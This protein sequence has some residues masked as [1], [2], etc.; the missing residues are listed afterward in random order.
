MRGLTP[1][2]P[3]VPRRESPNFRI[4]L[5][6]KFNPILHCANA[7]LP[8]AVRSGIYLILLSLTGREAVHTHTAEDRTVANE[9]RAEKR[10]GHV[11]GLL[12]PGRV[13]LALKRAAG[14]L[15]LLDLVDL[16]SPHA[17]SAADYS[18]RPGCPRR[19]P[20]VP[21]WKN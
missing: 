4:Q 18:K 21:E 8:C 10:H 14:A 3:A 2:L 11:P 6:I 17:A 13:D 12:E 5:S 1:P 9:G 20:R 15:D 7:L 16:P 19:V